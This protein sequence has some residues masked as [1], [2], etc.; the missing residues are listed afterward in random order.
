MSRW[1]PGW[2]WRPRRRQRRAAGAPPPAS[3]AAAALLEELRRL[4]AAIE[5]LPAAAGAA[6]AIRPGD[7]G[8]ALA[9]PRFRRAVRDLDRRPRRAGGSPRGG[10]AAD[11]AAAR[12]AARRRPDGGV[13]AEHGLDRAGISL[14]GLA[15]MRR[16][17]EGL[18]R[19]FRRGCRR[20]P[21]PCS[22]RIIGR[23]RPA[24]T[25]AAAGARPAEPQRPS[26]S[27]S[28]C[29]HFVGQVDEELA[30][31]SKLLDRP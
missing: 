19:M 11:Q 9:L 28:G 20:L 26:A 8:L 7:A 27:T 3:P 16:E 30:R 10:A 21:A 1:P 23:T 22:R 14:R 4:R 15:A 13:G 2:P 12:A 31:S 5:D 29:A 17:L 24:T 18:G 25:R 6:P